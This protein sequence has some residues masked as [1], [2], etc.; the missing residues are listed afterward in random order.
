MKTKVRKQSRR[1]RKPEV[2]NEHN[3]GCACWDCVVALE[4]WVREESF[5]R[6]AAEMAERDRRIRMAQ[7]SLGQQ[8]EEV[9]RELSKRR[10]VYPRLAGSGKERKSVLDYQMARM[11]SVLKTLKWLQKNEEAVKKVVGTP[12]EMQHEKTSA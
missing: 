8:I 7:F 4:E 3:N 9:E 12:A 2:L 1:P 10:E 11:E 5:I 6:I